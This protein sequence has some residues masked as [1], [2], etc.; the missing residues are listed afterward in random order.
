MVFYYIERHSSEPIMQCPAY[1][2][3]AQRP[4]PTLDD[5]TGMQ[6][7]IE[8]GRTGSEAGEIGPGEHVMTMVDLNVVV[9]AVAALF[10]NDVNGR[11]SI[12]EALDPSGA[13]VHVER[14]QLERAVMNLIL[15]AREATDA[16]GTISLMT[17]RVAAGI[18]L[19]V[20]DTGGEQTDGAAIGLST[21]DAIVRR[22][23]GTIDVYS[24]AG[25]GTTVVV[26][27]P[28]AGS[29]W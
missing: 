17:A 10:R 15:N 26:T 13:V 22:A 25:L 23:G 12:V 24:A 29:G 2:V 9:S 5:E 19:L 3:K 4:R 1:A 8:T 6:Q 28:A 18:R 14:V 11:I 7:R 21:A 20:S 27:L 16:G